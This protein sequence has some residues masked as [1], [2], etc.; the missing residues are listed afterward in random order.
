M[1]RQDGYEA[2]GGHRPDGE[3]VPGTAEIARG[4]SLDPEELM[5][6][7]G[8]KDNRIKELYEEITAFRL[9]AD[10]ARASKEATPPGT[11]RGGRPCPPSAGRS[12]GVGGGAFGDEQDHRGVGGE[13]EVAA[14]RLGVSRRDHV[15]QAGERGRAARS[16]VHTPARYN[17]RCGVEPRGGR[18]R[19]S[20][21]AN[22][23]SPGRPV[24]LS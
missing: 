21:R 14:E 22:F 16:G 1:G 6:R 15:A 20:R 8:I 17:D 10:E 12:V 9:A 7:L 11:H 5:A 18:V 13:P 19:P 23:L 4:E 3:E 2:G 24:Y